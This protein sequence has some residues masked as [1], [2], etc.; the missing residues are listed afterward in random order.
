M[1]PLIIAEEVVE[2]ARRTLKEVDDAAVATDEAAAKTDQSAAETDEQVA[3][4]A[5]GL[6]KAHRE[7]KH[8]EPHSG[9]AT[10]VLSRVSRCS[11]SWRV[12]FRVAAHIPTPVESPTRR[13]GAASW[14]VTSS[15]IA[16]PLA[17]DRTSV[18]LVAT[19]LRSRRRRCGA[20]RTRRTIAFVDAS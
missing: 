15:A 2:E 4:V 20:R 16:L 7:L 12:I 10:K 13:S 9:A 1:A 11:C 6:D 3:D 19:V 17:G 5:R 18:T 14:P 8:L